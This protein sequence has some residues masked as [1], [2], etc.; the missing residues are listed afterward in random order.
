MKTKRCI[1][2]LIENTYPGI[3]LDT[4][5]TC[6]LCSGYKPQSLSKQRRT[7]LQLRK[8][9]EII[10]E[11]YRGKHPYDCLIALSGGKDSC[12]L[13]WLLVKK[14]KLNVLAVTV[15]TGFLNPV[16]FK[17][18]KS[19][20]HKLGISHLFVKPYKLSKLV[21]KYAFNTN[22]FS[23]QEGSACSYCHHMILHIISQVAVNKQI[24]LLCSETITMKTPAYLIWISTTLPILRSVFLLQDIGEFWI[25]SVDYRMA[26]SYIGVSNA[27]KY[28]F[29]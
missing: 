5:G 8:Q 15:D 7:R 21:F 6:N 28:F 13:A 26:L 20:T 12:Y 18:I 23:E 2:C 29:L 24:P 14:Y 11:T 17:N 4:S 19:L 22:F 25:K 9:F 3:Y 10:I 1:N 27:P 16:I